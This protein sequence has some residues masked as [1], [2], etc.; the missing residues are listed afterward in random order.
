M[1][2]CREKS[3][4]TKK[5]M[6]FSQET[7]SINYLKWKIMQKYFFTRTDRNLFSL[8]VKTV[9]FLLFTL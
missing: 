7:K 8:K 2:A 5:C 1:G 3:F 6:F 9:F 4:K